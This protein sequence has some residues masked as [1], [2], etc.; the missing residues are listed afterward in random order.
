MRGRGEPRSVDTGGD[1]PQG[2]NP[3]EVE[4]AGASG[5]RPT[6]SDEDLRTDLVAVT[7]DGWTEVHV[8]LRDAAAGTLGHER[9]SSL[10]HACRGPAPPGVHDRDR[11]GVWRHRE[12]GDA[13]RRR[14]RHENADGAR[15][16]TVARLDDVEARCRRPMEAHLGPVNLPRVHSGRHGGQ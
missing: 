2:Q 8:Q 14:Y 5:R 12:D 16:V 11:T 13:V 9:E 4:R 7:A 10:Q 15:R 1:S 6:Q 3:A